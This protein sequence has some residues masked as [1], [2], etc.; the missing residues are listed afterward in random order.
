MAPEQGPLMTA[1]SPYWVSTAAGVAFD[2][3]APQPH[4]IDIEAIAWQLSMECRW[5]GNVLFAYSVAQHCKLVADAIP[6]PEWR[7][8]G[9]LHDAAETI[10]RDQ[11]TPY[12]SWLQMQGADVHGL[13]RRILAVTLERFNLPPMTKQI[14]DAVDLADGR[15][16]ATEFRDVVKGKPEGWAPDGKPLPALIKFK[17]QQQAF[18]EFIETFGNTLHLAH[19]SGPKRVA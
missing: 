1:L 2:I 5:S 14:A 11:A 12:K 3:A 13:E 9:L 4:M 15:A 6:E 10:T 8:Y 16:L 18:D 17:P 7:I 19:Q